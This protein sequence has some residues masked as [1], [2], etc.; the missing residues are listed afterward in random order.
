VLYAVG[1]YPYT[2]YYRNETLTGTDTISTTAKLPATSGQT[3]NNWT[4]R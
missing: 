4:K 2:Y 1:S 3:E